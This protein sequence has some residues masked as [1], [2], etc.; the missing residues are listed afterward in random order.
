MVNREKIEFGTITGISLR[1]SYEKIKVTMY[2]SS[3]NTVMESSLH[4]VEILKSET[5]CLDKI[6]RS[7]PNMIP[8]FSFGRCEL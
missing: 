1:K 5:R 4:T 2:D 6:D 3:H 8:L 7:N